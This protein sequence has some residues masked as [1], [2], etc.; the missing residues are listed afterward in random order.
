M[1]L[2]LTLKTWDLL[3][4]DEVVEDHLDV[5]HQVVRIA[6][7]KRLLGIC[8]DRKLLCPQPGAFFDVPAG[9]NGLPLVLQYDAGD[10]GTF[11]IA[12]SDPA[13]A[14]GLSGSEDEA[15]GHCIMGLSKCLQSWKP[16][17]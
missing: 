15:A 9:C 7:W 1:S 14:G 6:Q 5:A 2:S 16:W 10:L 3:R 11:L 8:K 4:V 12:E 17:Q 13:T